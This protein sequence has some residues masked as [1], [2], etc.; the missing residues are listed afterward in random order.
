MV[1]WVNKKEQEFFLPLIP[2]GIHDRIKDGK[3]FCLG[4][5]SDKDNTASGV[6]L[7]STEEA[8]NSAGEQLILMQLHWLYVA[9]KKRGN[10]L[11]RSLVNALIDIYKENPAGGI[12]C[13]IPDEDIYDGAEA[14]LSKCG[15]DF[16]LTGSNEMIISK[17]DIEESG[18][19]NKSVESHKANGIYSIMELPEEI[20]RESLHKIKNEGSNIYFDALPERREAYAGDVSSVYIHGGEIMSMILFT[21]IGAFDLQL[22]ALYGNEKKGSEG[23]LK[24]LSHSSEVF[25]RNYPDESRIYITFCNDKSREL[26]KYVFPDKNTIMI[27]AGMLH[28]DR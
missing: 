28:E 19:F 14:F 20:F 23:M 5:L 18:R 9:E 16:K 1:I 24:L 26:A 22:V 4:A 2:E 17:K 27:R 12:I 10:G 11:G 6:L 15:F 25:F 13:H 8:V 21:G 7:F 3:W